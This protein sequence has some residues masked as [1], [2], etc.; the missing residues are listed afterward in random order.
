MAYLGWYH[1]KADVLRIP[2]MWYFSRFGGFKPEL[3]AVKVESNFKFFL[4]SAEV[5]Q[6]KDTATI[7]KILAPHRISVELYGL[8]P[9]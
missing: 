1:L 4:S 8:V 7:F 3:S 5:L 6:K 2:K 9:R